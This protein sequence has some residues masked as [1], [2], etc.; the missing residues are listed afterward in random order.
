MEGM[1][2]LVA[3]CCGERRKNSQ[4]ANRSQV[5]CEVG[6]FKLD[7]GFELNDL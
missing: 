7:L 5:G 3:A 1:L 6:L 4:I 2:D